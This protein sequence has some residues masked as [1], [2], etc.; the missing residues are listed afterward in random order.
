MAA[1]DSGG[2]CERRG[3]L[4]VNLRVGVKC[5]HLW[6]RYTWMDRVCGPL[7]KFSGVETRKSCYWL[8]PM[9]PFLGQLVFLAHSPFLFYELA[10]TTSLS[11][12]WFLTQLV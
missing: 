11:A 4:L 1:V 8:R 5:L 6:K 2:K 3:V 12:F 7:S 9:C 10:A